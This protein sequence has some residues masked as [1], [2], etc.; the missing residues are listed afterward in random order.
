[1]LDEF[2]LDAGD[3]EETSTESTH[4]NSNSDN[5]VDRAFEELLGS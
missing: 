1:M 2:L 5:S 3:A 4:Y